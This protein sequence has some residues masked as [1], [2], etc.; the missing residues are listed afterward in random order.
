MAFSMTLA[1]LFF[2][3]LFIV[4]PAF[5]SGVIRDRVGSSVL[6]NLAEGVFRVALFLGYLWLVGRMRRSA[7][8][9]STTAPSTRPSPRSSTGPRWSPPR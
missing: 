3:G 7:G 1:L 9:S 2:V 4:L 5:L 8:C 6:L